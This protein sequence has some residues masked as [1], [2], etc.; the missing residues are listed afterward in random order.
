M[1]VAIKVKVSEPQ[2]AQRD[3]SVAFLPAVQSRLRK[4]GLHVIG[5]RAIPD[6][7]DGLKPVARR[8]VWSAYELGATSKPKAVTTGRL[9][10]DT[11]GKYHP[12]AEN[13]ISDAIAT[14]AQGK[15]AMPMICGV[16]NFGS[17][18]DRASAVRYTSC[19][20]SS[21]AQSMLDPDEVEC[22]EF[23]PNYDDTL[24]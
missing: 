6:G 15:S 10:G 23:I 11:F 16:G 22:T 13:S 20:L 18:A 8:A 12:H 17:Y 19:Y 14:M 2:R 3:D 21:V 7:R 24:R 9:V 5:N 1:R 4:Y